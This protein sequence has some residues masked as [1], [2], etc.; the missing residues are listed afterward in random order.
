MCD[1]EVGETAMLIMIG[2]SGEAEWRDRQEWIVAW[3]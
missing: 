2:R 1:R 3:S